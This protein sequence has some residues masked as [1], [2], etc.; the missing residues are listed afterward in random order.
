MAS[1]PD[2]ES[3]RTQG[4]DGP[5]SIRVEDKAAPLKTGQL[6]WAGRTT[7]FCH[8]AHRVLLL[9]LLLMGWAREGVDIWWPR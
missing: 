2:T 3:L 9:L 1:R 5:C 4:Y 8:N 7:R 6:L